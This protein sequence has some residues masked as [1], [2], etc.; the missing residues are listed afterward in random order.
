MSYRSV[1][2]FTFPHCMQNFQRH[3]RKKILFKLLVL[4]P[5]RAYKLERA[6]FI[7]IR[8]P[9]SIN[10]SIKIFEFRSQN[11]LCTILGQNVSNTWHFEF[12][13]SMKKK[14]KTKFKILVL[15]FVEGVCCCE[16]KK[17]TELSSFKS[18]GR[19]RFG[20]FLKKL[21]KFRFCFKVKI[22]EINKNQR[23]KEFHTI[24]TYPTFRT[25]ESI[26]KISIVSRKALLNEWV[27]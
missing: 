21:W 16:Y 22:G 10:A 1:Y 26:L 12:S 3:S 18:L 6:L 13:N 20:D 9:L 19:D 8:M 7:L 23:V 11:I 27:H 24:L 25:L 17:K 2:Y 15:A 14:T 5:P 4:T